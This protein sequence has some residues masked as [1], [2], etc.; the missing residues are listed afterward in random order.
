[1]DPTQC[2]IADTELSGIV[3]HDH[4]ICHQ[5]VMADGAPKT[6][7]GKGADLGA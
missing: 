1:M 5:A 3:G 4:R 2:M 7:S 6:R